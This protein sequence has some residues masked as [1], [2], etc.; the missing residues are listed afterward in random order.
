[1]MI[2]YYL[3]TW[4]TRSKCYQSEIH[5]VLNSANSSFTTLLTQTVYPRRLACGDAGA[6]I[7]YTE[8]P[9]DTSC[10]QVQRRLLCAGSI[11]RLSGLSKHALPLGNPAVPGGT[12]SA[13]IGHIMGAA[14]AG[15]L[16]TAAIE[17]VKR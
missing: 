5:A 2:Y 3:S 9:A 6:L 10:V 8:F 4:E 16:D 1:M 14:A 17:A 7:G 11:S 15:C 13:A 12:E